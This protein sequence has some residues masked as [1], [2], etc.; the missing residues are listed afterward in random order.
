[1][2]LRVAQVRGVRGLDGTVRIEILTDSPAQRF[3]PR[4]KVSV[5]GSDRRLTII[6]V[7]PAAPGLY[8]RFGEVQSRMAGERLI[9]SYLTIPTNDVQ[10]PPDRVRWDEVIGVMVRTPHGEI[11]GE[12][13]DLYRA[14]GAEVYIVRTPDG[15][16]I[17]LPAVASVIVEFNPRAGRIVADLTGSELSIRKATKAPGT[18]SGPKTRASGDV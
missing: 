6:D 13:Q 18:K 10:V 8:V 2:A 4:A 7:S 1:M 14:G 3:I 12:I 9:G 15:G 17:D 11:I 5:E 16:E